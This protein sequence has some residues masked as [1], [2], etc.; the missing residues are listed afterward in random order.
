[1]SGVLRAFGNWQTA[2][3]KEPHLVSMSSGSET[4]ATGAFTSGSAGLMLVPCRRPSPLIFALILC[5]S[6]SMI[7]PLG[8]HSRREQ[9]VQTSSRERMPGM[10]PETT[11]LSPPRLPRSSSR[12]LGTITAF[13]AVNTSGECG[14]AN[15]CP[16]FHPVE[17]LGRVRQLPMDHHSC[18][19]P[20]SIA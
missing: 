7:L 6:P 5:S 11:A 3:K 1:L 14:R 12:K 10:A 15:A 17:S 20:R 2:R 13:P 4:T 9:A 8:E 19:I 18:H 16:A